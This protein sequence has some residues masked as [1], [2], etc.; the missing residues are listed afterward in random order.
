MRRLGQSN[1]HSC[2]SQ[3]SRSLQE[4]VHSDTMI[5]DQCGFNKECIRLSQRSFGQFSSKHSLDFGQL[6]K[7]KFDPKPLSPSHPIFYDNTMTWNPRAAVLCCTVAVNMS[8]CAMKVTTTTTDGS[9]NETRGFLVHRQ[10]R[11]QGKQQEED[12]GESAGNFMATND[13]GIA[14]RRGAVSRRVIVHLLP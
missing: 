3:S 1:L 6:P 8:E 12:E 14:R 7:T 11:P 10:R 2:I 13:I 9:S 5:Q 4:S